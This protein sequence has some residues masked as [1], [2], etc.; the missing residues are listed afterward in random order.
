MGLGQGALA[1]SHGKADAEMAGGHD[2][3]DHRAAQPD[4]VDVAIAAGSFDT[5]VAAV[6][7]AGLGETLRGEGPYTV[8]APTDEAFAKIPKD[9]LDALLADREKLV[10]VLTYHVVPGRVTAKDVMG[11]SSAKTVQGQSVTI[12]TEDG[13]RIDGATVI[14]TDIEARNGVIHVIDTVIFPEA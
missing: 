7:T 8:F 13:V 11:L 14:Q 9:Q 10:A 4:I 2:A 12:A 3:V 6:G 1:G 5:L